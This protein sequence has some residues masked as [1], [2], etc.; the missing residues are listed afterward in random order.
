MRTPTGVSVV[1]QTEIQ[2][3]LLADGA[4]HTEYY[5]FLMVTF[6]GKTEYIKKKRIRRTNDQ[7]HSEAAVATALDRDTH[8]TFIDK[9]MIVSLPHTEAHRW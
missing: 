9:P 4:P 3:T 5:M 8:S 7:F 1:W 6:A 2:H